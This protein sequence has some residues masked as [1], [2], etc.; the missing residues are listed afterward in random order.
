[1]RTPQPQRERRSSSN[2]PAY[3]LGRPA[4]RW[5]AALPQRERRR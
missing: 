3:Y 5:K 1:M 4:S 2:F